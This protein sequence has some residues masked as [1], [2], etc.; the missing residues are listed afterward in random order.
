MKN[1]KFTITP[2]LLA[3]QGQRL[4][5]FLLDLIFLYIIILSAGTTILLIAEVANIFSVSEWV[6]SMSRNE[7]IVYVLLIVFLYYSLT[8]IYFSRTLAKLVTRTIVV[9]KEGVKPKNRIIV[10]RTLCR[11]IPFEV[12][13]FFGK[14]PRGWHDTVSG[15]YV[16]KKKKLAK[17]M[18]LF[19]A[20]DE[21]SE[22]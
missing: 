17:K 21:N 4:L 11:F 6:K 9:N 18:K 12:F 19:N 13:T 20:I 15:T 10:I 3:S 5:N 7:I 2:N 16:V 14:V 8:E 22:I 1:N